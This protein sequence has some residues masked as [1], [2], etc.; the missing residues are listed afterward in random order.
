MV[1]HSFITAIAY[2][3]FGMLRASLVMSSKA[4]STPHPSSEENQD[5]TWSLFSPWLFSQRK[6]L[7]IIQFFS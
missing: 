3:Y 1:P 5:Q 2:I 7:N 4:S 6:N